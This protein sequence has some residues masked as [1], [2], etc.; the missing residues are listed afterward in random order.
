MNKRTAKDKLLDAAQALMLS[1][2]Y[3]ATTVDEICAEAGVSKGSFYHFFKS[4]EELGIAVL[5]NY[6]QKGS[7]R[8]ADGPYLD[9]EDPLERV[10]GFLDYIAEIAEEMWG[11]GCLLG[12]F[13][14]DLAETNPDLHGRV[15]EAFTNVAKDIAGNFEPVAE[16][17]AGAELSGEEL[18]EQFLA[19]LEGAIVLAKAHRDWDRVPRALDNFRRYLSLLAGQPV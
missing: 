19:V 8:L 17:G 1:K 9:I 12:T 15:S 13:A 2:G 6:F 3:P 4:K 18:A 5:E 11:H 10:F 16:I 7:Q 14:L